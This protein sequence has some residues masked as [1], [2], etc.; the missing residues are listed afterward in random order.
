VRRNGVRFD[1][2]PYRAR[3]VVERTINR[4]ETY[5]ALLV[6]ACILL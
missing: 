5:H 4:L 2:E 1:R 6:I 3:N